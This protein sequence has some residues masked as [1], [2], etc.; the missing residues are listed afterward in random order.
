MQ[1]KLIW[2]S[3]SEKT[4]LE[5]VE[6]LADEMNADIGMVLACALNTLE[7]IVQHAKQG[8]KLTTGHN[9]VEE[10]ELSIAYNDKEGQMTT[11]PPQ[12]Q[13]DHG[14]TDDSKPRNVPQLSEFYKR[15]FKDLGIEPD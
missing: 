12:N 5:R 7:W 13:K 8:G 1:S 9:G 3:K 15:F 2:R 6:R 4:A 14:I 11:I 10:F